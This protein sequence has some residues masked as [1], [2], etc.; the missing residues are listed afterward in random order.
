[1]TE[2]EQYGRTDQELATLPIGLATILLARPC[3]TETERH[4][5]RFDFVGAL[6][7]TVG[8][9]GVVYGFTHASTARWTDA[10]TLVAFAIGVEMLNMRVRRQAKQPVHLRPKPAPR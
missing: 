4:P 1:M 7:S 5:G 3:L 9:V 2:P 8:M 6:T 10:G